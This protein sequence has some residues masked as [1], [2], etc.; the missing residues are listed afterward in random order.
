[1]RSRRPQPRRLLV[2]LDCGHWLTLPILEE[3][4]AQ[5]LA[6]ATGLDDS[7]LYRT[8]D[9]TMPEA[10]NQARYTEVAVE[11]ARLRLIDWTSTCRTTDHR[12]SGNI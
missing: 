2:T 8:L 7:T 10:R 9:G 11:H 12:C 5:T 3:F 6:A 4:G 1:M